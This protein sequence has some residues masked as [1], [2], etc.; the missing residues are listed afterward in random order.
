[1][2]VEQQIKLK[3]AEKKEANKIIKKN[4]IVQQMAS[5]SQIA[6][7]TSEA[8]MNAMAGST[9]TG[10][11]PW[12]AIAVAMG[13][14]QTAL[15][16]S[17]KAPTMQEGGLIG[18]NEHESGGTPILA[19]RGEFVMNRDAVENIGIE[20]MENLNT[21]GGGPLNVTFTGNVLSDDF[22]ANEAVPKLKEALR[23]GGDIGIG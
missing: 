20:A 12:T 16:L 10:G 3:E 15:V 6:M 11:L 17:Q 5:I 7:K 2:E 9:F 21:G 4:F 1:M 18:G 22:I 8:V 13:A 14:A 23:R 19:E